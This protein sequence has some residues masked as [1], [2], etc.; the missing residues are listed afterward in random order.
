MHRPLLF[1]LATTVM[2]SACA[3][4]DEQ[5]AVPEHD[6]NHKQLMTGSRI[7]HKGRGGPD[8]VKKVSAQDARDQMRVNIENQAQSR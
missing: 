8:A 3:S 6:P 2:L 1:A 7:A 5:I 4:W